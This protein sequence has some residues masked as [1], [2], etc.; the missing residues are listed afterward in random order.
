[1][2]VAVYLIVLAP[3]LSEQTEENHENTQDIS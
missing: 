2:A 1:M 3:Y